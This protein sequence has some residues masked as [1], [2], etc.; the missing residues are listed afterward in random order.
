MSCPPGSTRRS[1]ASYRPASPRAIVAAERQAGHL[2]NL[3]PACKTT[4]YACTHTRG[5]SAAAI[6]ELFVMD[7]ASTGQHFTATPI[8][9]ARHDHREMSTAHGPNGTRFAPL[10]GRYGYARPEFQQRSAMP[11]CWWHGHHVAANL[12]RSAK[13]GPQL[14][15]SISRSG[16]HHAA[17]PSGCQRRRLRHLFRLGALAKNCLGHARSP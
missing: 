6:L 15:C 13:G 2:A 9:P 14:P 4:A 12:V 10:K 1:E 8:T 7:R 17:H 3:H 5:V 16:K 11:L